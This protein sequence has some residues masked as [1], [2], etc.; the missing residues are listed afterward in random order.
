MKQ[1]ILNQKTTDLLRA[2]VGPDADLNNFAVFETLALNTLPL[3]KR[4]SIWHGGIFEGRVLQDMAIHLQAEKFVPLHTMHQ[5]SEELPVGRVFHGETRDRAGD[6][7]IHTELYTLFYVDKQTEEGQDLI[8]KLDSGVINEVSVGVRANEVRCSECG[9]DY[10]GE[11]ATFWNFIDGTCD[12]DHTIGVDGVHVQ[13]AGGLD[14]FL[15]LSLVSRGAA[16]HTRILNRQQA[17]ISQDESLRSLAASGTVVPADASFVHASKGKENLDMKLSAKDKTSFLEGLKTKGKMALEAG[18]ANIS[19]L[20][21]K[22]EGA[23]LTTDQAAEFKAEFETALAEFSAEGEAGTD[24]A[25]SGDENT[26]E[27]SSEESAEGAETEEDAENAENAENGEGEVED[28][29]GAPPEGN[30]GGDT[31]ASLT[32]TMDQLIDAKADTKL[33]ERERDN[34][35]TLLTAQ[36]SKVK[37]LTSENLELSKKAEKL[38]IKEAE[39]DTALEFLKLTCQHALI[40]SGVDKPQ[41]PDNVNELVASIK[42]A[43]AKLSQLPVGGVA[44]VAN[45]GAG[46][47][48]KGKN[49]A[50]SSYTAFKTKK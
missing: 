33:A 22:I 27:G 7:R 20:I 50:E 24:D 3:D 38:E 21:T 45:A 2:A 44:I 30:E 25:T 32:A 9:F 39:L 19:E 36:K 11:D 13:L 48:S 49:G 40:A 46:S 16:N 1:L 26:G 12:N 34:L 4:G 18:A 6:N 42:T 15:E 29:A 14:R 23:E 35:R 17:V 43:H 37:D 5:S 8:A 47:D 10:Y 28:T 41:I 31:S